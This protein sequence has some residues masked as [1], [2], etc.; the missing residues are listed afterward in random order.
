MTGAS[1]NLPDRQLQPQIAAAQP[2]L[3]AG[4]ARIQTGRHR[5]H[6]EREWYKV[7]ISKPEEASMKA[8]SAGTV[9][10]TLNFYTPTC[11][12]GCSAGRPSGG[13]CGPIR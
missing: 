9:P 3:R 5:S 7:G 8:G 4:A 12:T 11:L 13:I 10:A 2:G 1:G 6:R